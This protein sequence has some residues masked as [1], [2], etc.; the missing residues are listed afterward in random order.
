[1]HP[2]IQYS[3]KGS[4]KVKR[5]LWRGEKKGGRQPGREAIA[6]K[7][8]SFRFTFREQFSTAARRR[9]S[10][11][12]IQFVFRPPYPLTAKTMQTDRHIR[13]RRCL[14]GDAPLSPLYF[15]FDFRNRPPFLAGNDNFSTRESTEADGRGRGVVG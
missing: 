10:D 3:A 12:Q 9:R 4:S 14:A 2:E 5:I 1:M 7:F 15:D 6:F 13:G 8:R 11:V